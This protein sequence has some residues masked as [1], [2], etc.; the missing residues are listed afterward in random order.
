MIP[1]LAVITPTESIL[2]TSSYVKVPPTVT[3]P[4]KVPSTALTLPVNVPATPDTFPL[5]AVSYTHLTL[6]TILLV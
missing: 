5:N 6:P 4:V 2:V 3:L 1:F